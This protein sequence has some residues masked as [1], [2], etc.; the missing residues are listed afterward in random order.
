MDARPAADGTRVQLMDVDDDTLLQSAK[1]WMTVGLQQYVAGED[2]DFAIHHVGVAIEHLLKA[3]L[4]TLHP[5]LVVDGRDF[6]SLLHA[7]GYGDRASKPLSGIKSIMGAEAFKRCRLLL[8]T[9]MRISEDGYQPLLDAR[10]GVSHIG[11]HDHDKARENLI[12]AFR[13]AEPLLKKLGAAA[14][15]SSKRGGPAYGFWG[16]FDTLRINLLDEH[17]SEVKVR[18]E[19]K[20]ANARRTLKGLRLDREIMTRIAAQHRND[21]DWP[22]DCP[23]CGY[24]GTLSGDIGIEGTEDGSRVV[25]MFP[26]WFG[27]NV[28][29]LDLGA[30]EFGFAGLPYEVQTDWDPDQVYEP[31]PRGA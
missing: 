1:R 17:A 11:Y 20:I 9:D 31:G 6:D 7:T 18:Y 28:C 29:D 30:D 21:D 8:K 12:I 10:N 15:T 16:T 13:V 25:V 4:A 3:Y 2:L 27:C 5:A 24:A 19:M 22:V 26:R 23:V 14:P